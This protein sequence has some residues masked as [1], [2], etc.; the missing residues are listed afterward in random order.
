MAT[1][2]K[3]PQSKPKMTDPDEKLVEIAL[4][5]GIFFPSSEI[6]GDNI[7]GLWD[8]GPLGV[9]IFNNLVRHWRGTLDK[10]RAVEMSGSV[11]LPRT[12]LQASGHEAN[13]FDVTITCS[14]CGAVYR[15]DKLLEKKEDKN[16]EGLPDEE[17]AR[18]IKSYGI[19]CE[20]CGG[21]LK[22]IKK[23]GLMFGLKVGAS[24]DDRSDMNAYLRPEACQSIFLSFRRL[25]KVSGGKLP[26]IIGQTGKAFRNEI[27]PRNNLLRQ[28]EFYHSDIEVFFEDS[29]VF[30]PINDMEINVLDRK[31]DHV[32]KLKISEAV[33][34]KVIE[35]NVA[36]YAISVVADFLD[37]L[38]FKQEDIRYRKLYEEK[39]FY[40]KESFDVEIRKGDI[41]VEVMACNHRGD[42][43]LSSYEKSGAAVSRV[44]Q[45]LPNIFEIS[46]GTD[47]LFYLLLYTTLKADAERTWFSLPVALSPYRAAV[48]PLLSKEELEKVSE[49]MVKS[50]DYADEIYY[51]DSGSIGKRYRKSDEIGVPFA[52]TVD[53]QTLEDKTVTV[54]DRE[55]MQQFRLP[56]DKMDDMVR[57][58]A[59]VDIDGLRKRYEAH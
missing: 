46:M 20:K 58:S 35:N 42:Y 56:A 32:K 6:F 11:I 48:F 25:F 10:I 27:S 31:N 37:G 13:F 34:S 59:S 44:N 53:Y 22:T 50:S 29:T 19:R 1:D 16:F 55:T 43:D 21:E 8:Y 15:V 14:K 24:Q 54:R 4:S 49:S 17:Y 2:E 23:F 5:R 47:R 18:L 33:K 52:F 38:G 9:K 45:A 36:A 3:N 41:W 12:V 28:R 51:L 57:D 30:E 39:A 7:S 40:S 26:L